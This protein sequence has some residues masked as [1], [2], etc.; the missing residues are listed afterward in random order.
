MKPDPEPG[1]EARHHDVCVRCHKDIV[2]GSRIVFR[3]GRR[4]HV[5]CASGADDE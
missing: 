3:R 1:M 4:I 5:A 2:P